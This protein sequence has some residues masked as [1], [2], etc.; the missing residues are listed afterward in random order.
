MQIECDPALKRELDNINTAI[1]LENQIALACEVMEMYDLFEK[2][3]ERGEEYLMAY[4]DGF[5]ANQA[6]Q[7]KYEEDRRESIRQKYADLI[8]EWGLDLE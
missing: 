5:F 3:R 4:Q 8:K 6:L 1:I 7:M 2:A